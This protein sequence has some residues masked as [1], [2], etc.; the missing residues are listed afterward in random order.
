MAKIGPL[1][2][3]I[4]FDEAWAG[5]MKFHPIFAGHFAMGL[6]DLGPDAPGIIA[7]QSTHKQLASFSQ[8][9]QIHVKDRHIKGQARRIEHRRFNETFLVHAS[10]SPFYPL[11]ASLDVGAQMMKGKSGE[12][13][14][15]DTIRLGIEIRKKIRALG[16][17]FKEKAKSTD[18]AWFF[19]PFVADEVD[20]P[21]GRMRLGGG[22]DRRSRRQPGLL[23]LRARR[24]LARLPPCRARLCP[25]RPLQA[26]ADHA[27]LRPRDR[28]ISRPW[29][30]GAG[31]R[32]ISARKPHRRGK[33][34]P[35]FAAVPA[36]AGRGIRARP[37]R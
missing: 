27:G 22:L 24:R 32:A 9:S 5:F 20:T 1:C 11:F 34:R 15:D 21:D 4:L 26:D 37:A 30:A 31:G 10:T 12:V 7:T 35:Q 3:Y 23:D 36:D 28:R 8:A 6:K 33:E 18:R 19:D 29:R 25:D 16:Q 14:W 17:E 13:L 2:D